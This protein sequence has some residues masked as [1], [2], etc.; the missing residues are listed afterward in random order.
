MKKKTI[1]MIKNN[2]KNA[3]R[4]YESILLSELA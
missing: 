1:F 3:R 2:N 4:V